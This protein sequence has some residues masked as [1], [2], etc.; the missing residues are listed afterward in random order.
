MKDKELRKALK[1]LDVIASEEFPD[2]G[3]DWRK[4]RANNL[5]LKLE[6]L[7]NHLGLQF[8]KDSGWRIIKK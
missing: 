1:K 7:V 3:T 6:C 5:D 4:D 8:G 2:I